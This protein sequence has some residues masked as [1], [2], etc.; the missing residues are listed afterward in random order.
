MVAGGTPVELVPPVVPVVEQA[1]W[2][3]ACGGP[4]D[5]EEPSWPPCDPDMPEP[6]LPKLTFPHP[7]DECWLQFDE[8]KIISVS[9]INS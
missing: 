7:L 2:E 4:D 5:V 6:P 8:S 9:D 3:E 1:P